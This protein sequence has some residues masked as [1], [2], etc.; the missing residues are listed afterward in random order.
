MASQEKRITR[1]TSGGATPSTEPTEPAP[2]PIAQ[3]ADSPR[4]E[5]ASKLASLRRR[6]DEEKAYFNTMEEALL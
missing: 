4:E 6:I 1:A 2:R 5:M 3:E